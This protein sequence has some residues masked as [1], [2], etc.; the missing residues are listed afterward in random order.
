MNFSDVKSE[1]LPKIWSETRSVCSKIW[2]FLDSESADEPDPPA[3]ATLVVVALVAIIAAW[4][5]PWWIMK[6]RAPQYGQRTLVVDIGVRDVA[7]DVSEIDLLGHY[8]GIAPMANFAHFERAL[9]PYGIAATMVGFL[10]APWLRKRYWRL[11][12][13]AP[14]L[15]LPI[16][17]LI[18]LKYWMEW[19]V[20]DRNPEAALQLTT[21]INPQLFGSYSVGQFSVETELGAGF[22]L[23]CVAGLLGLGLVFSAPLRRLGGMAVLVLAVGLAAGNPASAA[24]LKVGGSYPTVASALAAAAAGDTVVVPSGVYHEHLVVERPVRIEGLP[25]AVIDGDDTGTVMR[26]TSPGVEVRGLTVRNSGE[27]L[28]T[29]DTGI[30]VENSPGVRIVDTRVEGVLFGISVGSS[31]GC[32][33]ENNRI[34]GKDLPDTHRGD[35]IRVSSS[36]GCRIVGNE[37]ERG[38]DLIIWYSANTLVEDNTVRT[39]RYGLHYMY[40]NNNVFRRN[41]F[42]DNQ[43]GA[44]IMYSRG[45]ELYHNAFSFSDGPSAYGL[46]VKDADDIFIIE[47]RFIGNAKALFFDGAPQARDGRVDVRGN[48]IARNDVGLAVQPLT[49]R[50]RFWDNTFLGNSVQVEV[51]GSGSIGGNE[52]AVDGRGNYWSDGAVYDAN[53]DG[54]SELPY[55]AESAYEDLAARY[56]VLGFFGS[57]P[58]AEALDLAARLFPIFAPRPKLAD[59]HPLVDPPLNAWTRTEGAAGDGGALLGAGLAL[60]VMAFAAGVGA[61]RVLS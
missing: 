60:L 58:G 15:L 52:W 46:L 50:V 31:G 14:A 26:I 59:P 11:L 3:A 37:I 48:L 42:E 17:V 16:G 38:R 1:L 28:F 53:G 21:R 4:Y 45:V 36:N 18:D 56:P 57:T 51:L 54:V 35:A 29:E 44:V 13:V 55:R 41:R 40:S 5:L 32:V 7:G 39:S 22:F 23:A 47:N 33:L 24:D 9:A 61:R 27:G 19:A 20:N 2:E 8:V 12:M 43:V 25:G 6:A 10:V 34:I 49:R 30:R